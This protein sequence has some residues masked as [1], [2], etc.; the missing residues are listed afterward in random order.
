MRLTTVF[1]LA[2]LTLAA[3]IAQPSESAEAQFWPSMQ[4]T[5]QHG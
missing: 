5:C 3:P 4:P 1:G 2:T